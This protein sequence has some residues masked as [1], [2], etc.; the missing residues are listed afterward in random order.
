VVQPGLDTGGLLVTFLE[1]VVDAPVVARHDG[2]VRSV[3]VTEGQRVSVGA[4]LARMENDEQRLEWERA[5]ALA[6][7]AVAAFERAKKLRGRDV[8]S[9]HDLELAEAGSRVARAEAGSAELSYERCTLRSPISGVVRLVRAEPYEIVDEGEI[10][11]R[12]VDPSAYRASLYLPGT[13]RHQ[14]AKGDIVGVT[15]VARPLEAAASG[16][17]RMVNPVS[18]PITGLFRVEIEVPGASGLEAGCEVVIAL[19]DEQAIS[20]P[21]A[22]SELGGAILPLDA[23]VERDGNQM[24]V[25]LL[26]SGAAERVAIDL[27]ELG[28]DGFAVFSGIRAGDLVLARG[29]LPPPANRV[30]VAEVQHAPG[31]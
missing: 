12:V 29:E 25:Y 8:I 22:A 27:G 23:Y 31:R 14:L 7:Q 11:F 2:I 19:G 20:D 3:E 18:D 10:L 16:R 9:Q 30:I 5:D 4:V 26:G 15:P 17:V 24:F 21:V 6:D 28:P 1:P 13:M